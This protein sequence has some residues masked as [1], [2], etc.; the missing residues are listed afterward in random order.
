MVCTNTLLNSTEI[1]NKMNKLQ[2][3]FGEV[4]KKMNS[5]VGYINSW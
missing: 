5:W 1:V 4:P 2:E 3:M